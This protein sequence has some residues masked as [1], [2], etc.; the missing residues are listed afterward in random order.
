MSEPMR[1][2]PDTLSMFIQVKVSLDRL[3]AFLLG[4]ELGKVESNNSPSNLEHNSD[5]CV[6][7]QEGNFSWDPESGVPTVRD[8]SLEVKRGLKIAVCGP[9]GSGK[10]TIL[11]AILGEVSKISGSVRYH[12]NAPLILKGMSCTFKEGTRVGVVG[13]TGSGKTT[14]ISTVFR[15]VEP[16][17][18]RILID[19]LDICSMR[20]KDLRTKLSIIPQEPTL[21]RGSVRT[22]LD[23]LG[24]DSDTKIW[25]A[26]E[27]CQVNATICRLPM[28]LDSSVSDEGENWS[29]G[30][31]QLFCLGRIPLKRNRILVL[32]EA[33]AS[34]DSATDATLQRIIREEFTGCTVITIAHRVPTITDSDKVMVLSYGKVVEYDEPSK[35]MESNSAFA[36]LLS[37][38]WSSNRKNSTESRRN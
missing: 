14:L 15:L 23:P 11:C 19:G 18:G 36:N 25:E 8:V 10:S 12:P 7:I 38:Y 1:L 20:L 28:L 26:L 4:E 29:V 22:N 32:D 2:I 31:R 24:I 5:K 9:A 33:T 13:R 6:E 37:E 27:K 16:E 21:F 17:S 3:N 30:P 34:I 35:L